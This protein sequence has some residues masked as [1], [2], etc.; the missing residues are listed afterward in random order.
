[1]YFR[2]KENYLKKTGHK[3]AVQNEYMYQHIDKRSISEH[4]LILPVNIM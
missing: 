2:E 1:M 4:E 3:H